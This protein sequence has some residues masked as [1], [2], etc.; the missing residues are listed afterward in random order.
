MK[1]SISIERERE[2]ESIPPV[3]IIRVAVGQ[4]AGDRFGH[5]LVRE[6]VPQAVGSHHQNIVSPVLILCQV[7]HLHLQAQTQSMKD[8]TLN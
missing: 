2:E 6:D 8:F 1:H 4:E 3:Q 7:I 5:F